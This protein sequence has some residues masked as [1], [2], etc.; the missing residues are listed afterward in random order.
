MSKAIN[1]IWTRLARYWPLAAGLFAGLMLTAA[2]LFER[3][4][5]MEPCTLCY[6]QR[7]VYWGVVALVVVSAFIWALCD[8]D[9][10]DIVEKSESRSA[11]K[12]FKG[13]VTTH[14]RS[15]EEL[16]SN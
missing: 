13:S 1:A 4:G 16:P 6:R 3:V 5:G 7:E 14:N 11:L 10:L 8:V 12:S 9:T 15:V 2:H